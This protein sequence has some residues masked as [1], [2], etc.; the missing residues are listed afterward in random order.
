MNLWQSLFGHREP[1]TP[2]ATSCMP[3]LGVNPANGLPMIEGALID[4]EGNLYGCSDMDILHPFASD[5]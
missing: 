2:E 5:D 1:A 4:I 3:D